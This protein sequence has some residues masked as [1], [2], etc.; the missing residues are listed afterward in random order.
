[1]QV[2]PPDPVAGRCSRRCPSTFMF[3]RG[4]GLTCQD[5]Y[6][7]RSLCRTAVHGRLPPDTLIRPCF[8]ERAIIAPFPNIYAKL[9]RLRNQSRFNTVL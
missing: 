6:R 7:S 1:M 9:K 2:A 3:V 5:C 4:I 8:P